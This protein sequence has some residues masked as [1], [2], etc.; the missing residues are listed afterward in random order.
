MENIR[1]LQLYID[2]N[3]FCPYFNLLYSVNDICMKNYIYK[4]RYNEANIII[5][6]WEH[7]TNKNIINVKMLREFYTKDVYD[8]ITDIQS[9][10]IYQKHNCKTTK[11]Q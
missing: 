5:H 7:K 3:L 1:E 2:N 6:E 11:E 4:P 10:Y 8:Y 9:Q